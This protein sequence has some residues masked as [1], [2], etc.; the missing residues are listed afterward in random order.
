MRSAEKVTCAALINYRSRHWIGCLK[1]ALS[2]ELFERDLHHLNRNGLF[3][4]CFKRVGNC[5]VVALAVAA[6]PDRICSLIRAQWNGLIKR[7]RK[8]SENERMR[9]QYD[10]EFKREVIRKYMSGQTIAAISRETGAHENVPHRWKQK[11]VVDGSGEPD[12]E[13]LAMRKRILELEC[14]VLK[15]AALI[16]GRDG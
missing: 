8:I 14:E 2:F 10:L 12:K 16:F 4:V 11:M 6:I 3:H 5:R 7:D 15:K 13:K 9:K 1:Q